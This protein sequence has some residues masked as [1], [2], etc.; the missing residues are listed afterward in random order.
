MTA[1]AASGSFDRVSDRSIR[2]RVSA[3]ET[4]D[5]LLRVRATF[6]GPLPEPLVVAM[7]VW[8]PGSYLVREHERHV[9]SLR[10]TGDGAPAGVRKVRK[11]AWAVAHGGAREVTVE[12][13]LYARELSVR[14]NYLDDAV[15][16]IDGAATFVRPVGDAFDWE[17]LPCEVTLALPSASWRVVTPMEPAGEGAWRA[18][19]YHDLV[20]SPITAGAPELRDFTVRGREHVLAVWGS[21]LA[22]HY[23]GGRF[24][25]DVARIVEVEAAFY[26]ELP[27]DRYVFIVHLAVGGRGGLEHA[28]AASL[29]ASPDAFETEDGYHD[30]LSLVAHEFLHLWH[31]KRVRPAGLA[32]PD[33]GR[34]NHTRLLWLFE[35][36]TSY[37]DR[38][39]LRRAGLVTPGQYLKHLAG[40]IAHVEETPGRFAQ[41]LEEAS[42]DAWIK[43]Y[44]HDEN[45]AN[46]T[47]SYYRKG[48]LACAVLDLEIRARSSGERSLDDVMRHLW[49]EYGQSGRPMPEGRFEALVAAAT[50]VDLSDVI[51]R[52]IRTTEPLPYESALERAGL[53]LRTR[54]GRG[55]TLGVRLRLDSGRLLVSTVLRG[56][57][58]ARAGISPG[59]EIIGFHGRRVDENALRERLRRGSTLA[60]RRVPVL[61]ARRE[62]LREITVIP[63]EAPPEMYEI[64]PRVDASPTQRK[65]AESWLECA[66]SALWNGE[67]SR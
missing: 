62:E 52:C 15:L 60:G 35:G 33:Y 44:R 59:D 25:A 16:C 57:P 24:A 58:A 49:R 28:R 20:D 29:M 40:E 11:D 67:T 5:H 43:L 56:G 6:A 18:G 45:T 31:V 12:Y 9:E 19:D 64:V 54:A 37:Y 23:D 3:A 55:V 13:A 63:A 41:S 8:T 7:P 14:T 39:L 48:E 32:P 22:P 1:A 47:V 4:H 46:S 17:S 53:L 65:L 2:Y 21:H 66:V 36:G 51:D 42:F 10:A 34:E 61:V 27:Y 50:G 38:L 26:G 30:L